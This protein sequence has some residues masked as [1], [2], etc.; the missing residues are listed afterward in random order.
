MRARRRGLTL[1]EILLALSL[2]VAMLVGVYI[3]FVNIMRARDTADKLTKDV[4]LTRVTLN[5]IANDIRQTATYI[6]GFGVGLFGDRHSITMFRVGMPEDPYREVD[7]KLGNVPA[8]RADVRKVTYSLLTTE[9][10]LDD[11]GEPICYGLWTTV[12]RTLNQVVVMTDTGDGQ[13]KGFDLDRNKDES[14][15]DKEEGGVEE[16]EVPQGV[17]GELMAPEIKYL[18][19][20]YFDGVDWAPEWKG[21]ERQEN[22]LPQAIM[23]TVGRIPI[24][25]EEDEFDI[26]VLQTM[27][28]EAREEMEKEHPDRFAII[29]RLP[30]ADRFLQSRVVNSRNQMADLTGGMSGSGGNNIGRGLRSGGGMGK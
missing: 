28:K 30:Q 1:L 18:E 8:V 5:R 17:D 10:H 16:A 29:V 7:W 9:E 23:I 3:F 6:P 26:S 12:Q 20:L 27:D 2:T 21:G 25:R 19:F 15:S 13:S 4:E 11:D 14:E 22:A 24:P